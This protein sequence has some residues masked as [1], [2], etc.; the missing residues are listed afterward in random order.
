MDNNIEKNLSTSAF[1]LLE[2]PF[3]DLNAFSNFSQIPLE[4]QYYKSVF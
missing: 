4:L 1:P 2:I 3:Y